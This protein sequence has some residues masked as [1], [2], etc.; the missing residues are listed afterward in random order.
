MIW[1]AVWLTAPAHGY[2][3]DPKAISGLVLWAD[4]QD[5]NGNGVQPANGATITTWVDKSGNGKNLTTVAGTV[6]FEATGFDGILPGLR[7]PPAARMASA[8][9]FSSIT[10]DAVTIFFINA[11]VTQ[12]A[13]FSVS[14]NGTNTSAD[15]TDGRF[16]FHTPWS[17]GIVYFDA[18]GCCT[19]G[20][21]AGAAPTGITERT[22][23]TGLND[24]PGNRQWLRI[25]GKPFQAD[26][27]GH[28][29]N[30]SRGVHLGSIQ[31][32]DYNGRFAEVV[33]YNRALSLAEVQE[34]ECYLLAK[35]KASAAPVGCLPKMSIVKTSQAYATST[36]AAFNI[37]GNDALYTVTATKSAGASVDVNSL[38]AVDSLPAN[39]IFYNGDIDGAGPLVNP[40]SFSQ[41]GTGLTFN[42][43]S[44]V[45]YSNLASP[46]TSFAACTYSPVSGYD[47]NVRHICF[48]PK[49]TLLGSNG[50]ISF[51]VS[52]RAK[53]K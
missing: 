12:T 21:L 42:Y 29:V 51:S 2:I 53:I 49:G 37:P 52:F 47:A 35:W 19:T 31:G 6:T 34:V 39:V 24:A 14:L 13:N 5:I 32:S 41:V 30:I 4:G 43:G 28:I 15:P 38:F 8:N 17:S 18:G 23:Y 3:P 1:A 48:N 33:V 16:S 27:T 9:P 22:L 44:D 45:R 46:P 50:P 25:D 36:L 40:I 10:R 7:F 26:T 11:N 20:R